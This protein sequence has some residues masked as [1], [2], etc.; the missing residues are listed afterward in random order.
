[1]CAELGKKFVKVIAVE[2]LRDEPEVPEPEPPAE[3]GEEEEEEEPEEEPEEEEEELDSYKIT[4]LCD[5]K[6]EAKK[7]KK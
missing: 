6:V 4:I 2:Q 1:M 5:G 7:K 3:E